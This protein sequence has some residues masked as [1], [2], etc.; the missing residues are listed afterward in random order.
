MHLRVA[1]VSHAGKLYQYAQLVESIRRPGHATP[2]H[3]LIASLGRVTDEQAANLKI[4]FDA[5]KSGSKVIALSAADVAVSLPEVLAN[6]AW[7]DVVAVL[8][9][10]RSS[11]LR[12]A[13][14]AALGEHADSVQAVDVIGALIVQRCVQPDSKLAAVQWF[15]KT[16]L[17][18]LLDIA[19]SQFNNSRVHRAMARLDG[20][21]DALQAAMGELVLSLPH[22]P[23]TALFMDV[24]DTWFFGA[25]PSFATSGKTKE[26]MVHKKI[27]I[28]LLC[29][30]R[31]TPLRFAVHEGNLDDGV[32]MLGLLR[33]LDAQA[34]L[35]AAPL[36]A[37]RALGNTAD[38][39]AMADMGLQYVTALC[40]GEHAVYGV[41]F[42]GDALACIDAEAADAV[43]Q[44]EMIA[45]QWGMTRV[46][47]D[48]YIRDLGP[49][50][51]GQVDRTEAALAL[52]QD[53]GLM[54]PDLSN[55]GD[56]ARQI[57]TQARA[58]QQQIDEDKV[59]SK[60]AMARGLGMSK[61]RFFERMRLLYLP[62]D[63][64]AEIDAGRADRLSLKALSRVTLQATAE[65]Q[66]LAFAEELA[67]APPPGE[68][69]AAG[70][71]KPRESLS[72]RL[73]ASFNP[74]VWLQKQAD[75][76]EAAGRLHAEIRALQTELAEPGGEKS[77]DA[78]QAKAEQL[79]KRHEM[80][81]LY[82][83]KVESAGPGV[84]I[85]AKVTLCRNQAQWAARHG[86]DGLLVIAAAPQIDQS[87][88]ELVR[89]Y[90]AKDMIEKDFREMKSVLALWPLRHSA[91]D[92]VRAHVTLCVLALA[93][94]RIME[95]R[96]VAAGQRQTARLA[97]DV[98]AA[99]QLNEMALPGTKQRVVVATTADAAAA[100]LAKA[101]DISWALDNKQASVQLHDVCR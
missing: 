19:P 5:N 69:I 9:V 21:D 93:I 65:L 85:A 15:A 86:R 54:D 36:V 1:R 62:A 43:Q 81:G 50:R 51:R 95:Q 24:T 44:A 52:G 79:L 99:V 55:T 83:V 92:K 42:P 101:L 41:D 38:F 100:A 56:R 75:H 22:G 33:K 3:K 16:A 87:A 76:R 60:S 77:L 25:G 73:I 71:R 26:G 30:Q 70:H 59:R 13:V 96:L 31:G 88:V 66:R 10:W 72:V 35:A 11:G 4:A 8:H 91:D 97:L 40:A 6:R 80:L 37:D 48:L 74:E 23:L 53:A 84:G 58:W 12:A 49:T 34:W 28:V 27:Q 90:R 64:Q 78:A 57:L 63:L 32:I 47:H 94:E 46:G 68:L 98:L 61:P 20:A 82:S 14:L 18:E 17:P 89:L 67:N 2:G 39:R 7:L 29:D 45:V